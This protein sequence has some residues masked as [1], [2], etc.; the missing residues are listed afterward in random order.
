MAG[1]VV[2]ATPVPFDA[3]VNS[4]HS[5]ARRLSSA[6]LELYREYFPDGAGGIDFEPFQQC[7]EAFANGELRSLHPEAQSKG[8]GEP[9]SDF[10]FLFAEFAFLCVDSRIDNTVWESALNAFVKTQEIFMHVY[11]PN[12]VSPPPAV[13]AVLP[14]CA[15]D[16]QGKP[17]QRRALGSFRNSNFKPVGSSTNVGEGQS[18]RARKQALRT[19]YAPMGVDNLRKAAAEN[20]LRAQCMS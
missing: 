18:N 10:Y 6:Q 13:S 11:R 12:P 9:N 4:L 16:A 20:M 5:I 15:V 19:K 17:R 1:R 14:A 3:S 2:G 8:V 7:F